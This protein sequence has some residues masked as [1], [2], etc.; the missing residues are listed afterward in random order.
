MTITEQEILAAIKEIELEQKE[1]RASVAFHKKA[2]V[3]A[4]SRLIA[5]NLR[6]ENLNEQLRVHRVTSVRKEATAY[7]REI[8]EFRKKLPGYLEMLEELDK[9]K[10]NEGTK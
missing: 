4:E 2:A 10:S 7:D 6:F 1:A 9:K 8:E 5:A 3:E